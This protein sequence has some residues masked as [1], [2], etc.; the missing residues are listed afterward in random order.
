MRLG[1]IYGQK[2]PLKQ[3]KA[4]SMVMSKPY[5]VVLYASVFQKAFDTMDLL[6]QNRHAPCTLRLRIVNISMV[7]T[8]GD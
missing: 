3:L 1:H 6:L 8:G 2:I 7:A 5:K 4:F